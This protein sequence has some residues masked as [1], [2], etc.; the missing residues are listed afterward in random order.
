MAHNNKGGFSSWHKDKQK[1]K[2]H[3]PWAHYHRNPKCSSSVPQDPQGSWAHYQQQ[4][5][6]PPQPQYP[7]GQGLTRWNVQERRE[8]Y[9]PRNWDEWATIAKL[10][11]VA[12]WKARAK[13]IRDEVMAPGHQS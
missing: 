7:P 2:G 3:D 12:T 13:A 4:W 5:N 8:W 1:G 6:R 9:N 10:E 11:Q